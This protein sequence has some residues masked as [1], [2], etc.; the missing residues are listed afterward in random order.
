MKDIMKTRKA[1]IAILIIAV[2][3]AYY[4]I[5]TGYMNRSSQKETLVAQVTAANAALALVP[6]PPTDLEEQLADTE[7]R[8]QALEETLNI[9]GNITRIVDRI[10]RLAE[11]TGVKAIPLSTQPWASEVYEDQDYSVFRIDLEVSGNFTQMVNFLN[12]LENGEPGTLVLE[13]VNVE[14]ESG[15]LLSESPDEGPVTGNIRIAIYTSAAT[16]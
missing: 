16:D 1:L 6:L 15:T 9:D 12:R 5:G 11:E 14:K 4:I 7:D 2:L 13:H 3:A 10:L 8:L